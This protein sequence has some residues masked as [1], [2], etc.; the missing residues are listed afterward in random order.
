MRYRNR[1]LL[2]KII[3]AGIAGMLGAG[4]LVPAAAAENTEQTSG[5]AADSDSGADSG[6]KTDGK[7][8]AKTGKGS[9]ASKALQEA[10]DAKKEL[11]KELEEAR[12]T[13]SDLKESKGNVDR[14]K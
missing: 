10:Q 4:T 12:Q 9:S 6:A 8:D 7:T 1:G 11:E 14:R 3:I 5:A 13:I 2:Q